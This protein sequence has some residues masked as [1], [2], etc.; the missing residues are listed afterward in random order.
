MHGCVLLAYP[1]L[2]LLHAAHALGLIDGIGL[3]TLSSTDLSAYRA[4]LA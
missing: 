4:S 1:D 3:T 2:Q